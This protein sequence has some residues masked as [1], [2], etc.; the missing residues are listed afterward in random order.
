VALGVSVE[1]PA[2]ALGLDSFLDLGAD[3]VSVGLSDLTMCTLAL[4]R[5]SRH[6]AGLFDPSHPAVLE[7]LERIEASCRAHQT[8]CLAAGE[9]ARDER[10]LPRLVEFG[11]DALGVS[12]SYFADA[13]R[14]IA[15]VEGEIRGQ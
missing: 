11:F 10:L 4:D 6:V 14:R 5:E 1:T 3:F 2:V 9:S 7:L 12:L 13:K 8:F 15:A